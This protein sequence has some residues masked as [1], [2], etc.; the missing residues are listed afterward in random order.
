MLRTWW[1]FKNNW[2]PIAFVLSGM[3]SS[4][5]LLDATARKP[6]SPAFAV[7]PSKAIMTTLQQQIAEKFLKK[8]AESKKVDAEIIDE[9]RTL[10]AAGKKLKAEEVV[11]VFSLPA[12]DLK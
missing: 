5:Q 6:R 1:A 8:L 7:A 11:K 10:L 3:S 2:T 9:L 4:F 12:G